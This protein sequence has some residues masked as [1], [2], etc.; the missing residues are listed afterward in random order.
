MLS[1]MD[2]KKIHFGD[3]EYVSYYTGD[4]GTKIILLAPHGGSLKPASI[5]NREETY[6]KNTGD[7]NLKLKFQSDLFTKQIAIEL[8]E[9]IFQTTGQKPH[10]VTCNLH[11][12]KIDANRDCYEAT[13]NDPPAVKVFNEFHSLIN[14]AKEDVNTGLLVDLHGHT[15]PEGWVELGYLF[16]NKDLR[17]KTISA[18]KCS[19]KSL[20]T[21][22]DHDLEDLVYGNCSLGHYLQEQGIE[23]VPSPQFSDAMQNCY[24]GGYNTATHGSLNNG[25]I[26]AVQLEIPKKYR[27]QDSYK[28]FSRRLAMGICKYVKYHY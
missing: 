12:R 6:K 18:D 21:R 20:V 14:T 9:E 11:R 13:L 24:T 4:K 10:L 28:G 27:N 15:H 7:A 25:T 2:N 8:R 26:D 17:N 23:V 22:S 1:S 16:S 3:E 5:P 19:I